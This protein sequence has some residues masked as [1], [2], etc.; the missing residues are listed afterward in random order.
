MT[1]DLVIRDVRILDGGGGA[2]V[3]GDVGV[4]SDRIVSVGPSGSAGQGRTEIDGAGR[5]LAPGLVDVH[6][7]DDGALLRHPDMAFKLAQGVTTVVIGNCGF[8]AAP[9]EIGG[10]STRSFLGVDS[11]WTDLD[12]F[13]AAV[14]QAAPAVNAVALVGHNSVRSLVMGDDLNEP[15]AAQLDAMK[16]HVR[17]AMAQGACGF[18]SGLIYHPGRSATTA[19]VAALAAEAAPF[20]GIYATHMRNEGDH[21]LESVD[22]ALLVSRTAGVPLQISH[23]KAAGEANWGKIVRSLARVHDAV[24]AGQD[25]TLDVY[26]Y[27]AG[28]GPMWQYFD[29]EN[30]DPDYSKV[31]RIAKCPDFPG[32]EGRMVVD[33]AEDESRRRNEPLEAHDIIRQILAGP[34]ARNVISIQFIIDEADIETNLR[35]PL[36]MVGSDGIADLSGQPHPRLFGTFPRVLGHYVRDR[37]VLPLAEAVRRMTSM[38]ADRFGLVDRGRIVEGG[39]ADLVLF[40]PE[41]V[42]DTATFDDPKQEPSGIGLVVVNGAVALEQGTHSGVGSG[43]LLRYRQG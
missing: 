27:V 11:T 28:S 10:E 29:A 24:D 18:S 2:A 15:D 9:A 23:H 25:V 14:D 20:G 26:P 41:T 16:A 1:I 6:S 34:G 40:D 19:E 42:I 32:F 39:Y 8:S 22:E 21:L 31:I 7:H 5:V 13:A 37:G 3:E 38:S 17:T 43:R 33:I 35:D 36:V 30:P 4:D 12:G